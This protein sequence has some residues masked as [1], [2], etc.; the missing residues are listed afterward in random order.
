MDDV[1]LQETNTVHLLGLIGMK[2]RDDIES[3]TVSPARKVGS[4]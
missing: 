4:L 3:I 1:K 2:W